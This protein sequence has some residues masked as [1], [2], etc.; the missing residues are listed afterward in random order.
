MPMCGDE[1]NDS[2]ERTGV[3]VR[4]VT[5]VWPFWH[6]GW[7]DRGGLVGSPTSV[8]TTVPVVSR[9][10]TV[11]RLAI[12][13]VVRPATG[14]TESVCSATSLTWTIALS[15]HVKTPPPA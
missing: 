12:S 10:S 11:V 6:G 13:V 2:E 14:S 15:L 7:G 3:K 1:T 9:T 4:G 8:S 5:E